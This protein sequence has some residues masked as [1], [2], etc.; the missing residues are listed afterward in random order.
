MYLLVIRNNKIYAISNLTAYFDYF[1]VLVFIQKS[2]V[3]RRFKS[4]KRNR[5]YRCGDDGDV[6]GWQRVKYRTVLCRSRAL[7]HS[8]WPTHKR[9][10]RSQQW[11]TQEGFRS[12]TSPPALKILSTFKFVYKL[13]TVQ[14]LFF[15]FTISIYMQIR[16]LILIRKTN[17]FCF[18]KYDTK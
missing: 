13:E 6:R 17:R 9:T 11:W 18:G 5:S 4:T 3:R 16:I 8:Y 2:S 7:Q 1:L 14:I 15:N 12:S 10:L